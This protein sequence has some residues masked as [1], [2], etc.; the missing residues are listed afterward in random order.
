M[1]NKSFA[2]DIR[3]QLAARHRNTD[4]VKDVLTGAGFK[5]IRPSYS[6]K[7]DTKKTEIQHQ[8]LSTDPGQFGDYEKLYGKK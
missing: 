5:K 4:E 8:V 2:R 1:D 7:P 3:N 6:S